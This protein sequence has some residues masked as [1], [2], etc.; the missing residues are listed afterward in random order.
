MAPDN[1]SEKMATNLGSDV[2]KRKI[3]ARKNHGH[4]ALLALVAPNGRTW[5]YHEVR[6]TDLCAQCI[7]LP[8]TNIAAVDV[9]TRFSRFRERNT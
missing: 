1:K 3:T 2:R 5:G 7:Y 9:A 6:A 4:K 8:E